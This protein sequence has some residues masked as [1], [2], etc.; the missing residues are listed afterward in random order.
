MNEFIGHLHSLFLHLPIGLW[1]LFI[2]LD[3]FIGN[4]KSYYSLSI[5]K[6]IL[7]T[8]IVSSFIA[9]ITGY[10]QSKNDFYPPDNL[11]IHQWIAYTTTLLSIC[12]FI[13]F[14]KIQAFKFLQETFICRFTYLSN[15]Y[16]LFWNLINTWRR[17]HKFKY[18][19]KALSNPRM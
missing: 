7:I 6:V 2:L 16:R 9:I 17:F 14:E 3:F 11:N 15:L 19:L 1:I 10:I 8:A 12:Y 18:L 13:A 5:L 4:Q